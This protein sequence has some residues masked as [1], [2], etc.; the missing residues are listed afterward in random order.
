[1]TFFVTSA[2]KGN[3]ADLGGLDGA[4]AHC[5]TLATA[6]GAGTRVAMILGPSDPRRYAP[7]GPPNWVSYVWREWNVPT[8]GVSAGAPGFSWDN[9]AT[10]EDVFE[11]VMRL[12]Y[13]GAR[14]P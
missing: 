9:G 3:G 1:M 12:L 6:V 5:Q 10:V 11:T 4:D 14:K 8:A 2:G 13:L 7:Y